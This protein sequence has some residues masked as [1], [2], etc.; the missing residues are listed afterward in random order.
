MASEAPVLI[1]DGVCNICSLGV[2]LML[3]A[4]RK[5]VFRFAFGQGEKGGALKASYGLPRGDL[6]SVALVVNG[7]CFAKSDAVLEVAR[8][9]PFPW[10]LLGIF[11]IVP[12]GWRDPLYSLVA[13]NRYRWFGIRQSCF[14]PSPEHRAR[15]IDQP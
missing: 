15:F 2:R 11:R 5:G 10:P 14:A 9:L 6:E 8:R 13:R 1:F 7:R 12:R 3:R 4:D